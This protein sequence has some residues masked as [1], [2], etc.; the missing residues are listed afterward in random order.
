[1]A[2]ENDAFGDD[3]LVA[4]IVKIR[5]A[6]KDLKR[7]YEEADASLVAQREQLD[8]E[9][10]RR[11]LER[12]ATQTKTASGTAFIGEDM[13]CTIAEENALYTFLD[14]EEDPYGWFQKRIKLERLREYQ[15]ANG[16]GIPPGLS[17]FRE[18]TI[19]VRA[20]KE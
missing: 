6:R 11:L 19:N 14:T 10:L 16:G 1:M 13:K 8:A 4:T 20:S 12:G 2:H 15:E 5:D 7:G 3:K 17:I 18:K 9:L